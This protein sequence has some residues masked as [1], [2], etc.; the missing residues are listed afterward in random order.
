M[1]TNNYLLMNGVD[2]LEAQEDLLPILKA[3]S[4]KLPED[5]EIYQDIFTDFVK[6]SQKYINDNNIQLE[7]LSGELRYGGEPSVLTGTLS[8]RIYLK[9]ANAIAQTALE[10]YVEPL[11]AMLDGKSVEEYPRE[12]L[13][14]LWKTLIKN[15]PHDSIC[16]CSVDAVHRHMMDR[17]ERIKENTDELIRRGMQSIADH[18]DKKELTKNDYTLTVFSPVPY[19]GEYTVGSEIMIPEADGIKNF[20]LIRPNGKKLPFT[21]TYIKRGGYSSITPVNLPGDVTVIRYGVRFTLPFSGAGYEVITVRPRNG[22]ITVASNT[23]NPSYMENEYLRC[24]INGNGTVSVTDKLSGKLYHGLFALEDTEETGDEYVHRER[25][26]AEIY[27]SHGCNAEIR[28]VEQNSHCQAREVK[29]KNRLDT[30]E[31][32]TMIMLVVTGGGTMVILLLSMLM[33]FGM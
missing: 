25:N 17:Y 10:K 28:S 26:E 15:H 21:V 3:V 9:Q 13:L 29:Y 5:C 30:M 2:H 14:Y 33:L 23:A 1:Q 16:G 7:T 31:K 24:E 18:V 4:D 22:E 27:T 32:K 20:E 6:R 19:S 8:S 12:H 11:Y